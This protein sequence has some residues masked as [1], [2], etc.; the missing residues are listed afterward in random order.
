MRKPPS[1]RPDRSLIPTGK[2]DVLFEKTLHVVT[3]LFG[4]GAKSMH[5]DTGRP[6]NGKS[7]RGH[8]RFWWRACRAH[9][10]SDAAALF[11]QEEVVW[12]STVT[13]SRGAPSPVD[14]LV[15]EIKTGTAWK[16]E[17]PRYALFP[18]QGQEPP[19]MGRDGVAFRLRILGPDDEGLRSE[20]TAAVRAWVLFGGIGSRT[21]RG[22]GSLFQQGLLK[23]GQ[24]DQIVASIREV[25]GMRSASAA[26]VRL[27]IPILA[28]STIVLGEKSNTMA[29]WKSA[30]LLMSDFRQKVGFARNPGRGA[31]PGHSLWP[32][33][34]VLQ[35]MFSERRAE[36]HVTPFFPRADLGLPIVFQRIRGVR[37][38]LTLQ[39]GEQGRTRMASPV[40]LKAL[41]VDEKHAHPLILLLQAPHVW[42]SAAPRIE[43]ARKLVNRV[44]QPVLIP[45]DMG[46]IEVAGKPVNRV[47]LNNP[48]QA[49]GVTQLL[50]KS[51]A[52]EAFLEFAET[53][54]DGAEVFSLS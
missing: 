38:A 24:P 31:R 34:H 15:D 23:T 53:N 40:I 28:G 1:L 17:T 32:E 46:R 2:R 16:P 11:E 41:P 10:F 27:P 48:S 4:G 26:D 8:L 29:A 18:F 47:A 51:T 20:V 9:A 52:R 39:G 33:A 44:G 5:V 35:S 19:A 12:G 13:K 21:R 6:V 3:P 37:E 30:V 50:K 7:I 22:C 25:L 49:K 45:G 42:D 14:V 43:V 54:L 36:E